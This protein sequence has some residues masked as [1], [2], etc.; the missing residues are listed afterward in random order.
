MLDTSSTHRVDHRSTN[1]PAPA[2][3]SRA[4]G[5]APSPSV[6]R[7]LKVGILLV[8]AVSLLAG[9]GWD[10]WSQAE[11]ASGAAGDENQ[12]SAEESWLVFRTVTVEEIEALTPGSSTDAGSIGGSRA[13]N[14]ATTARAS[15]VGSAASGSTRI[16]QPIAAGG[17]ASPTTT[18]AESG[19]DARVGRRYE[20][21]ENDLLVH[22]ARREYGS[23]TYA[24]LIQAYNGI[25]DPRTMRPGD[26]IVLPDAS[27][28][29]A[30]R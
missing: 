21:R 22:I 24:R 1:A 7:S 25:D 14:V 23:Q 8:A 29:D 19:P 18:V 12:A 15:D 10:R 20:I 17:S 13:G 27:V 28:L 6:E 26:V 2:S 3:S 16:F 9:V 11:P 30:L 4:A 5:A